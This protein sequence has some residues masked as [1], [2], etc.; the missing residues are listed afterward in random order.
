MLLPSSQS[1]ELEAVMERLKEAAPVTDQVLLPDKCFRYPGID[2]NTV[3]PDFADL[4][5]DHSSAHMSQAVS[6]TAPIKKTIVL[7]LLL[8]CSV[9]MS[10]KAARN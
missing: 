6:T 4:R 10:Q 2:G 5:P 7:P 9:Q 8:V 1:A 3:A